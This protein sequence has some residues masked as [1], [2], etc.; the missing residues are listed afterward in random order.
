MMSNPGVEVTERAVGK[1]KEN[2][3][4]VRNLKDV[5]VEGLRGRM[6]LA[7]R[8]GLFVVKG[9][10]ERGRGDEEVKK[11]VREIFEEE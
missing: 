9:V 8:Q 3:R 6:R 2:L 11:L 1:L 10:M 7:K 4:G 5:E